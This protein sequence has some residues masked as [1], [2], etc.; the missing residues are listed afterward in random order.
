MGIGSR[1][2]ERE[3]RELLE[4]MERLDGRSV[5]LHDPS[6]GT[7]VVARRKSA[8]P[9]LLVLLVIASLFGAW[10]WGFLS[11]LGDF[12]RPPQYLNVNGNRIAVPFPPK[13]NTRL[14]PAVQASSHGT[15]GFLFAL[16]DGKPVGYDPC[17][18][19]RYVIR[20][21]GMSPI[22]E[23][24]ITESITEISALTG[25]KFEYAGPTTEKPASARPVIQPSLY[26]EDW[27]PV[28]IAWTSPAEVPDLAGSVAGIGGSAEVPGADGSGEWLAAGRLA[29]DTK[30]INRILAGHDGYPQAKAVVL[31]ELGHVV[32]LDHV[33]DRA[34]LMFP[35]TAT[36]SD[37]G[38]GDREGLAL[39]G[40]V[41]CERG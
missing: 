10:R 20:P 7:H 41:S 11:A 1:R 21:D 15:H 14:L 38:P 23:R 39:V 8:L 3:L 31:H 18:P 29:L 16:P 9:S 40:Q 28:L 19:V 12:G 37:F 22:G 26:G 24:L 35:E 32:G 13:N 5:D 33:Q 36:L 6:F 25:L 30:D 17:R 34:E 2:R 27:A 4:R